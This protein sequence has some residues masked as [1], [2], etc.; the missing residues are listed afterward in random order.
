MTKKL[1]YDH[2]LKECEATVLACREGKDCYEVLLD[3]TV[4]YPEGGGQ[5]SD[6]GFINDA[7]VTYAFEEGHDIFNRC[8][9]AFGEGERVRVCFDEKTRRDHS[10]Q[11]TG[12]HILSG[13]AEGMFDCANVGFHMTDEYVSVDFDKQLSPEEVGR[14]EL[15]ANEAIQRNELTTYRIVSDKDLDGIE[16]RKRAKG[17]TGEIRLVYVGGV[18]SCTCCGTH[19]A[20]AGE[21]GLLKITS[22]QNYK[23]GTRIFFLCGMRAVRSMIQDA[24]LLDEIAKR[25]STKAESAVTAVIRQGEELAE[26][27]HVLKKRSEELFAFRAASVRENAKKAGH[28]AIVVRFEEGMNM[29]EL[30]FFAQKLCA[31]DRTVAILFS[32]KDGHLIYKMARTQGVQLSMKEVCPA[33]NAATGG[34]GGGRDDNAQGSAPLR[35]DIHEICAQIETYLMSRLKA[36]ND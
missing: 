24:S 25:F 34:K 29:N 18:D 8:D 26:T 7:K 10:Q 33:V 11:H 35:S 1:Y 4:I 31:A 36:A 30:A 9:R 14:L 12:E 16:L 20:R 17:L 32:E 21:V 22:H 3:Q 23:G 28:T 13:L 19:C 15:A 6:T 5:L 27:K 2:N